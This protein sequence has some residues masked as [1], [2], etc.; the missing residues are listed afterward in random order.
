MT[1]SRDL[2]TSKFLRAFVRKRPRR[3]H[4]RLG[5]AHDVAAPP[6]PDARKA[7]PP[8]ATRAGNARTDVDRDVGIRHCA[9]ECAHERLRCAFAALWQRVDFVPEMLAIGDWDIDE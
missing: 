4:Q 5:F 6:R 1:A 2:V 8:E 7:R 3:R 9:L